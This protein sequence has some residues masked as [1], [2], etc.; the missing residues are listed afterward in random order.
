MSGEIEKIHAEMEDETDIVEN[1]SISLE[2]RDIIQII[3]PTNN[4][5]HEQTFII[6]Y[7]DSQKISL[8][9]VSTFLKHILYIDLDGVFTDESIRQILLLDRNEEKGYARQNGL[10]TTKWVDIH[11]GGEIPFIVTGEITNLEEDMIEIT[12]FPTMRVLY[13]DFKYQG[14]PEELPIEQIVLR[15]RPAVMEKVGSFNNLQPSCE[16]SCEFPQ[17]EDATIEYT[18]TG[19]SIISIPASVS[20]DENIRDVLHNMYID[21][22]DIFESDEVE[23]LVLQVEV[24]ESK[25]RYTIEAQVNDLMDELLSTIPNHKRTKEVMDNIHFVIGRFVELRERFSKFDDN[26][27]VSDIKIKGSDHKP[28]VE[29]VE[30]FNKKLHWL[31]PVVKLRNKK[32][33]DKNAELDENNEIDMYHVNVNINDDLRQEED[34]ISQYFENKMQGDVS[35]YEH[36]F[37]TLNEYT[38][39]FLSPLETE[40]LITREQTVN[41]DLEAIVDNFVTKNLKRTKIQRFNTGLSKIDSVDKK[42]G[43]TVYIRKSFMPNDKISVKSVITLPVP[44]MEFS[45]IDLPGT[46][47]LTKTEK[48]QHHLE[49]SRLFN[50]KTNI[51]SHILNDLD[52]EIKY[53]DDDSKKNPLEENIE[54]LEKI[55]EFSIDPDLENEYNKFNKFLHSIIPKTRIL[56][57]LIKKNIN[58]KLSFVDVVNA[59]EPFMIYTDDI[60]YQQYNEIRYFIKERIKNYKTTLNEKSHEF[61]KI[62][63]TRFN[64]RAVTNK[65]EHMFEE[66]KDYLQ[67][68]AEGYKIKT[69]ELK[70][71]TTTELLLHIIDI[72]NGTL[73]SNLLSRV[74]LSLMTPNKL[75]DALQKPNLEDLSENE[76]IKPKDCTRRFLSKKYNSISDLQKDNNSGA[77]YYDKEFDDTPYYILKKYENKQKSMVSEMF[78]DYLAENLIQKHDC[79]PSSAKEMAATLIS[80]KKEVNDGEY[81]LLELRPKLPSNVDESKLTDKEKEEIE[82]EANTRLKVQYYKRVKHHWVKDDT[83]DDNAFIDTQTLFCNIAQSCIKNTNNQQC[84]STEQS[85]ARYNFHRQNSVFTEELDKRFSITVEEMEK[86]LNAAIDK[87]I[88]QIKNSLRIREIQLHKANYLAYELGRQNT[89][90]DIIVSQYAKLFDMILAQD[91]FVKKQDDIIRFVQEYCREPMVIELKEHSRWFYCKETNTKLVP[92]IIYDLAI[93]FVLG[94]YQEKQDELCR[95]YGRDEG[96]SIVDKHSGY[97]IRKL[98]FSSE[99]GYDEAGFK[100]NTHSILEK[101]LGSVISEVLSKKK[102]V[103]DNETDQN[104][105]NI[106][107]AIC[108]NLS[109]NTELIEEFVLRISLEMINNKDI[110]LEE[111]N[112]TKKTKKLLKD[113][114]KTSAPF[115]IYKNQ[116]IITI[117]A[118]VILV[119][120]QC[121][122]PSLRVR[123]TYPGCVRSFD[124]YPL[125]GGIEDKSGIQYISCVLDS[126]KMKQ[127]QSDTTIQTNPWYSIQKLNPKSIEQRMMDIFERYIDKRNDIIELYTKKKEYLI[128]EPNERIPAEHNIQKWKH[129][130]PPIVEFSVT[131]GLTNLTN[132]FKNDLLETMRK[133]H[134]DQMNHIHVIKNKVKSFSFGVIENIN[135]IVHQKNLL[136]NTASKTPFLQNACCNE[137]RKPTNPIEYFV[138]DEPLILNYLQGAKSCISLLKDVNELSKAAIL[139]HS[140]FT[141]II[142][143]SLPEGHL[144]SNIYAAFIHYCKFDRNAPVPEDLR[145]ICGEKPSEYNAL[146]SLEEKIDHL[147]RHGKRY[148]ID[149]LYNLMIIIQKRN[150]VVVNENPVVSEINIL[151]DLLTYM[152]TTTITLI[153]YPLRKLLIEVLESYVPRKM[154]KENIEDLREKSKE[155]YRLRKYLTTTNNNLLL[156][157]NRFMNNYATNISNNEKNKIS[158][159][160][161][162]VHEWQSDAKMKDTGL[163]YDEQLYTITNFIKNSMKQITN[164]YPNIIINNVIQ[165]EITSEWGKHWGLSSYHNSDIERYINDYYIDLDKFKGDTVLNEYLKK[166]QYRIIDLN[167]FIEHIPVET[168]VLKNGNVYFSLFDKQTTYLLFVYCWYSILHEYIQCV[169]DPNLLDMDIQEMKRNKRNEIR[170]SQN[171]SNY[172]ESVILDENAEQSDVNNELIQ[173]EIRRADTRELKERVCN[174]L[175]TFLNIEIANKKVLDRSYNEISRRVRRSKQEEKKTITDYLEN[176]EKDERKVEDMIKNFKLGRWNVGTQKGVFM[177]DKNT[178]D[179]ERE[180]NL[181]RF[182]QDLEGNFHSEGEI[183]EETYDVNDLENYDNQQIDEFYDYEENAIAHFGVDYMD[184]GYYGDEVE[185]DFSDDS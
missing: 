128:L 53:V 38:K 21:A 51:D 112:Y 127:K 167:M 56:F 40:N 82:M 52:T 69:E 154:M 83:I 136:L 180:S 23:E 76:R 101:D 131:K 158:D 36:M 97:V 95:E 91:D 32:Y 77:I 59:L 123:K 133:G 110:V 22:N 140:S 57:R 61:N 161:K 134:K 183:Q 137:S 160:L 74:L 31:L 126:M 170:E 10:I 18:E 113:K 169:N 81:A 73:F 85:E 108:S 67:I 13:I 17:R 138:E 122:I 39:P 25:K 12:T 116:S 54:F 148:T 28:L 2:L 7:I 171:T 68:F 19:E 48:G 87:S 6:N 177:Y 172:I 103:F 181:L 162:N 78:V 165:R 124:G 88:K 163:Y 45:Q 43:K 135:K 118:C 30:K 9:N 33:Y 65:I 34:V 105:Y 55:T 146:W 175:Y 130:L 182:A 149:D 117:V 114:G 70:E 179:Q 50:K 41:T 63:N 164:V 3:A 84:E 11:F 174:L 47:I 15:P 29:V 102:R 71:Y 155:V 99:E 178:Y 72:D 166:L 106:F 151:K 129:F 176:M 60:T 4:D 152:D 150:T 145:A 139:Y 75:L 142:Y 96:D 44:I 66:K 20:P 141:G 92:M 111:S 26:G 143:P 144:E 109:V 49:L 5:I 119:G 121:A 79:P 80:G 100:I 93:A 62:Q 115:P 168:P 86:E 42:H 125:T 58:D 132:E 16:T 185:E 184:E 98:D 27:N 46:N 147:K 14:I 173:M 156:E 90:E 8:V 159:F 37:S 94:T 104:V 157:I 24:P 64:T 35:K 1:N 153:E 107:I 120:I 89:K